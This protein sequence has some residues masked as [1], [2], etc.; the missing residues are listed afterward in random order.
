MAK[1]DA[2][3]I[4]RGRLQ[5]KAEFDFDM[6]TIPPMNYYLSNEDVENLRKIATSV[7]L[8]SKIKEKLK[9]IDEIMTKRGFKRFA[10][11]TNRVVY[12]FYEDTRFLVKVA[13]DRVGITD[14]PM[15]YMNQQDLKPFVA[16]MFYVSPCGTVGFAERVLPVKNK[17]EFEAIAGDVF[18]ILMN[19]IIGEY[20]LDD[21]GTQY[22][23]NWGVRKGFGPVL[24]DY[25]YCYKLDGSK[26]V[27]NNTDLVTKIPCGGEIDYDIGF[28]HLHC[29][30]C[31]R[32]FL[33]K[34]LQRKT[35]DNKIIIQ[36]GDAKMDI[37]IYNGNDLLYRSVKT[38]EVMKREPPKAIKDNSPKA[39]TT[40]FT[41]SEYLVIEVVDG[42][43]N[44]VY[45][46]AERPTDD[47]IKNARTPK[48]VEAPKEP[49]KDSKQEDIDACISKKNKEID[50]QIKKA[51]ELLKKTENLSIKDLTEN[52][53]SIS[54]LVNLGMLVDSLEERV[55][56]LED[57]IQKVITKPVEEETTAAT[58]SNESVE[59]VAPVVE[60]KKEVE[61]AT[62]PATTSKPLPPRDA[63]GH[64]I[65][66][67]GTNAKTEKANKPKIKSTFIPAKE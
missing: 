42:V 54:D 64:F 48:N 17:K 66:Q 35:D 13:V 59:E 30:K 32:V 4:L 1:V 60:E 56:D 57:T 24:L 22:F 34:E 14:N 47:D 50:E 19:K 18:D 40:V 7:R 43:R 8:A 65:S 16:K 11:G 25:P 21:I 28:N 2:F 33:A 29:L 38:D 55:E 9:M 31:G 6:M 15:E 12:S 58:E 41:G 23:M 44:V 39:T 51:N 49:T 27:C 67:K 5:T 46:G 20:V 26:L 62:K 52:P 36:E 3:D 10:A 53:S 37:S 63:K 61:V 45:R